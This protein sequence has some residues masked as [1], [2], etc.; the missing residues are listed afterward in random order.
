MKMN[1][2]S[3]DGLIFVSLFSDLIRQ[4]WSAAR[5]VEDG[6]MIEAVQHLRH[7]LRH[8]EDR[9]TAHWQE[10]DRPRSQRSATAVEKTC[11]V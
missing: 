7:A 5:L 10:M 4:H 8:L 9:S 1:Q 2:C 6:W 11:K 3:N